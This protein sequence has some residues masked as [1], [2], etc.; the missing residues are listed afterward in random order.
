ESIRLGRSSPKA[1]AE[2]MTG[3]ITQYQIDNAQFPLILH[4]GD[5]PSDL[6]CAEQSLSK[7]VTTVLANLPS[8]PV[9]HRNHPQW[10]YHRKHFRERLER[11]ASRATRRRFRIGSPLF[12][13][14]KVPLEPTRAPT[15]KQKAIRPI[16]SRI[17]EIAH[18]Y[19]NPRHALQR[20]ISST[21]NDNPLALLFCANGSFL[22]KVL[23]SS[24]GIYTH[25][26][27][28]SVLRGALSLWPEGIRKFDLCLIE[29][30]HSES[31][32]ITAL[33]QAAVPRLHKDS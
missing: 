1:I 19:K 10:L 7:H 13:V 5:L 32:T 8:A 16:T 14:P 33:L 31:A 6:T 24:P 26:T 29:L 4:S 27:T 22:L 17:L 12:E 15:P 21:R 3:Y 20:P 18:P 30:F 2:R 9:D 25:L 23:D 28:E 11:R